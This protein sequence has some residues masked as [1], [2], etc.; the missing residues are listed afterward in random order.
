MIDQA[1]ISEFRQRY[2]ECFACG[3]EN[4]IGLHIDPI[5][6]REDGTVEGRFT[7]RPGFAGFENTLHGGVVSTALDEISACAAM[8]NAVKLVYTAK[9]EIRFRRPASSDSE[10]L[11]RSRIT[12]SRGRRFMIEAEMLDGDVLV[13]S[14]T[15]LFVEAFDMAEES[16]SQSSEPGA[17]V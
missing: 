7:P 12:E 8:V 5:E 16:R 3:S 14:S 9:L 13:A 17:D 11:I 10:F 4:P 1:T 6:S 15:G 2:N